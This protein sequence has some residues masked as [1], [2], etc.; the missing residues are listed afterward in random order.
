MAQRGV[1]AAARTGA[2]LQRTI[3]PLSPRGCLSPVQLGITQC[4]P[5]GRCLINSATG[6]AL[7][8]PALVWRAPL[9]A[10]WGP[11][12]CPQHGLGTSCLHPVLSE[13]K[14]AERAE[15][16]A[17]C[18]QGSCPG[19]GTVREVLIICSKFPRRALWTE[20]PSVVNSR[21]VRLLNGGKLQPRGGWIPPRGGQVPRAVPRWFWCLA[22]PGAGSCFPHQSILRN[23]SFILPSIC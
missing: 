12:P 19:P 11:R 13:A 10:F 4:W 22:L 7:C 17:G 1:E 18:P 15:A 23:S 14:A 2:Q 3:K 21:V 20:Q 5:F 6:A 8:E 16:L 9:C